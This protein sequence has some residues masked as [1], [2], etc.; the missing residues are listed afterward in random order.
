MSDLLKKYIKFW[1]KMDTGVFHNKIEV[2]IK[3]NSDSPLIDSY[4]LSSNIL[5]LEYAIGNKFISFSSK[6]TLFQ[7]DAK[8]FFNLIADENYMKLDLSIYGKE[9]NFVMGKIAA[10]K[11]YHVIPYVDSCFVKTSE[12]LNFNLY[13]TICCS[14]PISIESEIANIEKLAD[15]EEVKVSVVEKT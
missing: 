11:E 8:D 1:P 4:N 15:K 7:L 2:E 12:K 9:S 13:D 3:L 6:N 10:L 14:T 5:V